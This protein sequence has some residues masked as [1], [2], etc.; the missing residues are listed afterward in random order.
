MIVFE[1]FSAVR[2]AF[3]VE[4]P[5]LELRGRRNFLI[6]RNGSGKTTLLQ[7]IAGIIEGR[8]R[9]SVNDKEIN[10]LA[11]QNRKAGMIPQDLL[12]FRT[13]NV[14][15]NLKL[16][17]KHGSGDIS[18]YRQIVKE[19]ELDGLLNRKVAEIS[20]GEAQRVAIARAIISRPMLLLMD[21]PFSF[22]D[23]VARLSM[24]SLVDDYSK[25]YGFDFIYATHNGRDLDGGFSTLI[26]I[27]NGRIVEAV[28]SLSEIEHFRTLSLLDYRNL[29][30]LDN[31]FFKLTDESLSFSDTRGSEY[32]IIGDGPNRYIRFKIE[33]KF[34]FATIKGEIR[35]RYVNFDMAKA[36]SIPY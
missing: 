24:I 32:E 26:S 11:V 29:V 16:P 23:E 27:D 20:Q 8:G 30:S 10:S 14:D 34:H 17:V 18:L 5:E 33:G 12:L 2:G 22:Q 36:K 9:I 19:M 13:M 3:R 15:E 4:I 31:S 25:E 1:D 7:A 21:E 28:S 6:G 35:G